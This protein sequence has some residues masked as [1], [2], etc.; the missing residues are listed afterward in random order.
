MI[1]EAHVYEELS[2]I[3]HNAPVQAGDTLSHRTA[4]QCVSNGWSLRTHRGL[5]PTRSG[6]EALQQWVSN[7]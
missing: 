3:V 7:G 2:N 4:N 6:V 5:I 1:Q